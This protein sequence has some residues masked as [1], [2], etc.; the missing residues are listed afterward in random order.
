MFA[1]YSLFQFSACCSRLQYPRAI[2]ASP[3][4][5]Y[6]TCLTDHSQ[7][8]SPRLPVAIC[9]GSGQSK[10]SMHRGERT[11]KAR[12]VDLAI[13]QIEKQFGKGSIM[14]LGSKEAV[15]PDRGHLHGRD[16]F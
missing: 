1:I 16:F 10:S 7:F 6:G 5:A 4:P 14:K 13:T 2:H 11:E 12:A 9:A 8:I 15:V 3:Q